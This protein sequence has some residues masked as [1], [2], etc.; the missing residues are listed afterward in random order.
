MVLENATFS[1]IAHDG[2]MAYEKKPAF[3]PAELVAHRVRIDAAGR[4]TVAQ[5]GSRIEIDGRRVETEA[6]DVDALYAEGRMQK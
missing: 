1:D 3:G 4:R 6:L 5:H 2:L